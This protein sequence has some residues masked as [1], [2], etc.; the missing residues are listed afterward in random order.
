LRERKG[1][2]TYLKHPAG[3]KRSVA[4]ALPRNMQGTAAGKLVLFEAEGARG[5]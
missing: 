1:P 5:I 2:K 3:A 4:E